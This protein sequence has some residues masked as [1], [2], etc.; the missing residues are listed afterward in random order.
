MKLLSSYTPK[1]LHPGVVKELCGFAMS[2]LS[3]PLRYGRD[4]L[5]VKLKNNYKRDNHL[6]IEYD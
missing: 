2:E 4:I 6:I 5:T 1:K 3:S